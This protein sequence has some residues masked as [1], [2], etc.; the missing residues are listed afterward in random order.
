MAGIMNQGGYA[1]IIVL[2]TRYGW[3]TR[4]EWFWHDI[5]PVTDISTKLGD[6]D[7]QGWHSIRGF[8]AVSIPYVT[9]WGTSESIY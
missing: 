1:D 9:M 5:V 4:T 8:L 7:F 6:Q 3:D 2:R